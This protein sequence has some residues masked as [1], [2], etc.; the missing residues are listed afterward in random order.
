MRKLFILS[1]LAVLALSS[2]EKNYVIPNQTIFY[3]LVARDWASS[4]GG[5]NYTAVLDVPTTDYSNDYDATLV[6]ISFAAG[7]YEQVPEVYNGISYS[8]VSR[9]GQIVIEI[10][11]SDGTSVITPPGSMDVKVVLIPSR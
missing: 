8:Y 2:C 1:I 11:S 10:Q 5:R 6:Y 4:N 9:S 3:P 7:E